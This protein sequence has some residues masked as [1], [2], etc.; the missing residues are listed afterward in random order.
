MSTLREIC[1]TELDLIRLGAMLHDTRLRV[2]A[3]RR[4]ADALE[5]RLDAADVV[6]Q[7]GVEPSVVTMNSTVRLTD[8]A[9]SAEGEFTLVYPKDAD[10]ERSRVSVLSP[11]GRALLGARV[12]DRIRVTVVNRADKHYLVTAV[13]YQPEAEGR[14]DL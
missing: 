11:L 13:L 2:P 6:H 9:S 7:S 10:P 4:S 1:L 5:E 3:E 14:Y 12:G 8:T